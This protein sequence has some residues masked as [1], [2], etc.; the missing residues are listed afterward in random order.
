MS[1]HRRLTSLLLGDH[2]RLTSLL[3]GHHRRLTSLLLG[4]CGGFRALI[5]S[6]VCRLVL[7]AGQKEF[8][9]SYNY[10]SWE[11]AILPFNGSFFPSFR[12]RHLPWAISVC[13]WRQQFA[14][15]HVGVRCNQSR[16]HGQAGSHEGQL[17]PGCW[18]CQQQNQ[19]RSVC[20]LCRYRSLIQ[21][22]PDTEYA[23][24]IDGNIGGSQRILFVGKG[25]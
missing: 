18:D 25:L 7:S 16:L 10:P 6:L 24:A 9:E 4:S 15:E 17:H 8:L 19:W 23:D 22:G 20:P 5:N 12:I 11:H 13:V 2:R 3:L 1:H 14:H 21:S